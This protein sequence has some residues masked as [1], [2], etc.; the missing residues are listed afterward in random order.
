MHREFDH[1]LREEGLRVAEQGYLAPLE[2]GAGSF[3]RSLYAPALLFPAKLSSH[4]W[5]TCQAP[6]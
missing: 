4:T 2:H 6:G 1:P 3:C 5:R